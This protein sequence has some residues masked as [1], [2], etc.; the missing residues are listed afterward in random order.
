M[1]AKRALS[2][3]ENAERLRKDG[4]LREIAVEAYG[5]L[6]GSPFDLLGLTRETRE[7]YL[8]APEPADI[9]GGKSDA[10]PPRTGSEI[11]WRPHL[12]MLSSLVADVARKSMAGLTDEAIRSTYDA[13]ADATVAAKLLDRHRRLESGWYAGAM[14]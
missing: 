7:L 5:R 3:G 13:S 2:A 10:A 6:R 12:K 1:R 8:G 4:K 11:A 14:A 9:H